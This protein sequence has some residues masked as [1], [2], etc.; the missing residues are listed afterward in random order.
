MDSASDTEIARLGGNDVAETIEQMELEAVIQSLQFVY[1]RAQKKSTISSVYIFSDSM[2]VVEGLREILEYG[3][4]HSKIDSR[5][6]NRKYWERL[7]E[8]TRTLTR[9]ENIGISINH[10]R[11]HMN[12]KKRQRILQRGKANI[13]T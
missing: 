11:A 9:G 2:P 6:C 4:F 1:E 10:V 7:I 5:A 12:G 13:P 3:F 8:I